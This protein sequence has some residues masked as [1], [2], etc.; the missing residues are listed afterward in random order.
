MYTQCTQ[1]QTVFRLSAEVLRAA[2][3]EVRCGRCGE[4]FNALRNLA[5]E[6][7]GFSH[8]ESPLD[9]EARAES[10]LQS[11]DDSPTTAGMEVEESA[12]DSN[13]EEFT[14]QDQ[15]AAAD[16]DPAREAVPG[17]AR[18]EATGREA[19]REGAQPDPSLEFTLPPGELDKIFV[20]L[21]PPPAAAT[22]RARAQAQ[23]AAQ[24]AVPAEVSAPTVVTLE[25]Q[26]LR[27][28]AAEGRDDPGAE[29][30]ASPHAPAHASSADSGAGL[31][32]A[33]AADEISESGPYARLSPALIDAARAPH[34]APAEIIPDPID[35]APT[36]S[37]S[38]AFHTIEEIS[39]ESLEPFEVVHEPH[40]G[41]WLAAAVVLSLTLFVQ[42]IHAHRIG[43]ADRPGL[44]NVVRLGYA[45]FGA[46]IPLRTN[47]AAFDLR[48]WGV[49]G[50]VKANGT[51]R[52]RASLANT[53][54]QP[55][56]YPLLRLVL[57][58]R[59]GT[60]IGV[61]DFTPAEYLPA[62]PLRPLEPGERVDV[63][64]EILDPGK[65]AEG[66]EID[67]C[68][69][70]ARKKISCANDSNIAAPAGSANAR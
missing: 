48:Q 27:K 51:L 24:R 5:E 16:P 41:V 46:P 32:P 56:P 13:L 50:D 40:R 42:W 64:I 18:A 62:P 47:L 35:S 25:V 53:A 7:G 4:I 31:A 12:A 15:S 61:R 54:Q 34:R 28:P 60:R 68:A 3:G 65:N 63:A 29:L 21:E 52:M 66:F 69:K 30:Q 26:P 20:P 14:H 43:L 59:F 67:V 2:A 57:A 37:T 1:C 9:E 38:D 45:I 11:N 33:S 6:P 44:G 22:L 70:S 8:D 58:D 10:I 55:Q 23:A 19:T 17:R 36:E 39:P 49:T